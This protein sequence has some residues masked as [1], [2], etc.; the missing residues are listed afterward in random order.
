MLFFISINLYAYFLNPTEQVNPA[1]S[2][3]HIQADAS[4]SERMA[5]SIIDRNPE[6]WMTDF[7]KTPKWSY[8]HGLI[9]MAMQRT[10][11]HHGDERFWDYAKSYADTMIDADGNI[12]GYEITDFNIDH[13][14]SGKMLFLLYDR[15]G[16]PRYRKVI[17]TLRTQLRWQPR[18]SE[19]G[20][21]H[22]RRYP[23]QMWLDGLY[24]GSPFLAEYAQRF[25]EKEAFD[26]VVRQFTLIEKHTLDPST[27]LLRHGWDESLLQ[28]WSD[29]QT[30]QSSHVWGRAMGWYAMALVDALDYFPENHPGRQ[31]LIGILSRLAEA[32][33]KFQ[34]PN[35]G[36]WYQVMNL[37]EREG[38]YEEAT[39]SCM[40]S[41]AL[42]R[43]VNQGYLPEKYMG[44]AKKAF[45]GIL[46]NLVAVDSNGIMSL[47]KCCAVAGLGGKPFRSGEFDYYI[48]E[49][50]RDNDPK[51]TGP[52]ILASLEFEKK[53]IVFTKK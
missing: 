44:V 3:R 53:G 4:W 6:A 45:Q 7:R 34:Q 13:I 26:D 14:N 40:L 31:E 41:Y 29:P 47:Q 12:K 8:T 25:D 37:P 24:M 42:S 30:G 22:K 21:W 48:S 23:W 20:F 27:G 15:L 19:G 49:A 50:I 16:D 35:S 11:Q 46:D 18:T 52:F 9:M 38:N 33:T 39:V 17:E 1:A 2:Q 5:L 32:V 28:K 43:G 36:L 51:G 10:W